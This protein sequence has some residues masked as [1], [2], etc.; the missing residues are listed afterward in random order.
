VTDKNIAR[1]IKSAAI[2]LESAVS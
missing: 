2:T 1:N